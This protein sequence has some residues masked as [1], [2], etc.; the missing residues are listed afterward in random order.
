MD[1][2]APKHAAS[3]GGATCWVFSTIRLQ[4]LVPS[5]LRGRVFA[6]E[7]AGYTLASAGVVARGLN[8]C[9]MRRLSSEGSL[10]R[11]RRSFATR[12]SLS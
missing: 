4:Q 1:P 9:L 12:V 6:S 11:R 5:T 8:L 3:I 10:T 7:Q 2:H